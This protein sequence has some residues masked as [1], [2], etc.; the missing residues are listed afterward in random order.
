MDGGRTLLVSDFDGTLARL[1]A[2]PWA[3]TIVPAARRA[4]RRLATRAGF[5]VVLLSGRTA[6]DLAS[7][8]R[9]G[10]ID[11]LGDHGSERASARRGFRPAAL[12]V[13]HEPVD[14]VIAD[15]AR[16]LAAEVPRAVPAPWL[17]V[18][19][20]SAAV[21]FHVRAA[22]DP[23]V[24]RARV[25]AAVEILDPGGVLARSGGRRSLELRPA[26]ASDKGRA[27]DR[28]IGQRRPDAVI[29]L[30]D[31]HT[32]ALAFEVLRQARG[33]S[34]V[35]GLAVAVASHPDLS[36]AVAPAADLQL[37]SATHA[38]RFPTLLAGTSVRVP[39]AARNSRR[40]RR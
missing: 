33:S 14:P 23:D 35:R 17:V 15:L 19:D 36:A 20:K 24:A 2:D 25:L 34:R 1:V 37:A 32:D 6:L 8:A 18:E 22:P 40:R 28:L 31:D 29:M 38:A 30:G 3:A 16:R 4:L 26:G 39:R 5:E 27:L 11:Y 13:D 10:G 9:V 12:H 7:R 21:T